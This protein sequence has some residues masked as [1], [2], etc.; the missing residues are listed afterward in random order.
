[1]E[2][3]VINAGG[4]IAAGRGTTIDLSSGGVSFAPGRI[5]P[6]GAT[7]QI[8]IEWPGGARLEVSGTVVRSG[9][10]GTA[11]R[12]AQRAFVPQPQRLAVAEAFCA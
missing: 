4:L 1:M 9:E 5:I 7:V 3:A 8:S 6:Q 2:Y 10:Q 12:S 11:M